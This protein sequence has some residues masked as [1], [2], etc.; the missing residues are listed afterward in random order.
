MQEL[1]EGNKK[2]QKV[3]A[4]DVIAQNCKTDLFILIYS[5]IY[6]IKLQLLEAIK[7]EYQQ[8]M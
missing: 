7:Q 2:R 5:I 4:T 6:I 3:V 8:G 1:I